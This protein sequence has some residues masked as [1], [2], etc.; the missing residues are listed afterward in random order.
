[1]IQYSYHT[2]STLPFS[3]ARDEK[4]L[5]VEMLSSSCW[6]L[7]SLI[8]LTREKLVDAPA[9]GPPA[10]GA[11]EVEGWEKRELGLPRAGEES[12]EGK[13]RW[14]RLRGGLD[15]TSWKFRDTLLVEGSGGVE[16]K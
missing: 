14:E 12:R 15:R 16:E 10:K 13:W 1:M 3:D 7:L 5:V 4:P 6:E 11:E 9:K 2:Q 8:S